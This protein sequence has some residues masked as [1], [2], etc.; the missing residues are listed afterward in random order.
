MT[1]PGAHW[2]QAKAMNDKNT[3]TPANT[4]TSALAEALSTMSL[5]HHNSTEGLNYCIHVTCLALIHIV[6][7]L[8][9]P[10]TPLSSYDSQLEYFPA[11]PVSEEAEISK[12]GICHI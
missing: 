7:L 2:T 5:S 6:E 3:T 1:S 11:E 8:S 12:K 4:W 9:E 10:S